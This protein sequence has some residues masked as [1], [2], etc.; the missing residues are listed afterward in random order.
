[1]LL[2]ITGSYP[3]NQ[4][5]IA[6]GAKVL[7][8]A[9]IEEGGE[10]NFILLTTDVPIISNSIEKN[11][12][13]DYIL[14]PNWKFSPTN[15]K[16]IFDILEKYDITTI[17]MEYPGDLYGKTFLASFLPYIVK[18][19]NKKNNKSITFN[20]RLHEFTRARFLR[21]MA[22]LP[23][24][25]SADRIYV[26][27]KKDRDVV[28]KLAHGNVLKTTIG[29]NIKVVSN[30]ILSCQK[31]TIAYF[32]SVYSGKGIEHL[33]SIWKQIKEEDRDDNVQFKIIGDVGIEDGNHFR[34]YHRQ[35]LRI[36]EDYGL[37]DDIVITGYISDEE[38]S[39]EIQKTQVATVFYEDG[40]T[41]RRG[42]FLAFL[43]HGIPIVTSEGDDDSKELFSKAKGIVMTNCDNETIDSIWKFSRLSLEERNE[44][45]NED[46]GLSRKFDW[47]VIAKTFLKDY[48]VIS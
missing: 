26:P 45:L 20:V 31:T 44:I 32:G 22:I 5:G 1:M 7:L 34:E 29:T 8:D 13:C 25:K 40:L 30:K 6:S 39:K 48:G 17:H 14:M 27:G 46:I 12:N 19:Y 18:K 15:I 42:S 41:L 4:E 2:Y 37:K 10:Q 11:S 23:I 28:S 16:R 24:L 38:V 47:K 35:V 21:K 9:M 33:L 43:A 36:I 3:E